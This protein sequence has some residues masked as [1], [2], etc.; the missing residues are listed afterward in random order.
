MEWI[1]DTYSVDSNAWCIVTG[2]VVPATARSAN[3]QRRI[4]NPRSGSYFCWYFLG[5][6]DRDRQTDREAKG[7]SM[8]VLGKR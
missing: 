2:V 5:V 3:I 4:M 7:G 1:W 6:G 8:K